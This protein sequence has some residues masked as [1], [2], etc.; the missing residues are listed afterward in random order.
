MMCQRILSEHCIN[1]TFF[2]D[3]IEKGNTL[4][5]RNGVLADVIHFCALHD[6]QSSNLRHFGTFLELF[7]ITIALITALLSFI[8]ENIESPSKDGEIKTK[9]ARGSKVRIKKKQRQVG[10]MNEGWLRKEEHKSEDKHNYKRR[11]SLMAYRMEE[12]RVGHEQCG[13][14]YPSPKSFE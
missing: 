11:A 8:G 5:L 2:G 1:Q 10:E 4:D 12:K 13:C 14:C 9:K 6:I 3:A 7:M